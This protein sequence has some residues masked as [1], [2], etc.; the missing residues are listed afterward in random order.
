MMESRQDPH[1]HIS[2][3][4]TGRVNTVIRLSHDDFLERA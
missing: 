3:H 2:H 1:L 4:S